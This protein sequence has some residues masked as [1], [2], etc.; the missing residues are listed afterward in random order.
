MPS[1]VSCV[2]WDTCSGLLSFF[3]TKNRILKF[4]LVGL[5]FVIVQP[6][7]VFGAPPNHAKAV[8]LDGEVTMVHIDEIIPE[9]SRFAYFLHP[10]GSKNEKDVVEMVFEG[11][12]PTF[13]RT[14]KKVR[15]RGRG[16]KGKVWISEV[17]ALDGES[18]AGNETETAGTATSG[19]RK[20]ITFVIN[21][22][23]VDYVEQGA[24]PYTQTHVQ[25]SGKAMHDPVEF[26]VNSAYE[27]ASFGQVTFSG[28]TSTDVFL[29]TIPYDS[30]ESCA[31]RTIASQAD[32][33]SPVSLQGYRH[34]L[35]VVPPK[36]ISG[37]GWLALG[38]VGSYGGTSVRKS[39][40]TRIDPIAFA[41]E[42]GHNI[43]WHHA[44]TDPDNDGT[45]NVEYGD[46]SDLM[47]YCCSKRKLN[48]VHVDQVGW[49]ERNDLQDRVVDVT[50]AGQYTLTPL[51]TDPDT[52]S[53]PQILRITPSVGRPYY[54]SYRQKTGMDA[55]MSST[56]TTG[57][58]IHRGESSDNWSYLVKVLKSDFTDANLYEFHD[59][60]N[61]LTITQIE[62][63]SSFVKVDISFGEDGECVVGNTQVALTPLD[64]TITDLSQGQSF[65]L[66]ITNNDSQECESSN[67]AVSLDS[68]TDAQGNP[69]SE[70]SG[71]LTSS[72]MSVAPQA[73]GSTGV[74][75]SF[76]DVSNG[77]YDLK[78]TVSDADV[79]EPQHDG[80]ATAS[81]E[82]SVDVCTR[83]TPTVTLTPSE[84]LVSD[85]NDLQPY[86]LTL[87]NNDSELCETSTWSVGV[88][89]DVE[90]T[91]S[92]STL[93]LVPGGKG[94]ATLA[95]Q[96]VGK[97]DGTY[98][99]TVQVSDS[100]TKHSGE[101]TA[102]L[103]LDLSGPTPPANLAAQLT[104]KGR[105]QAVQ[106]SWEQASDG[107]GGTG[108]A[109][110][111]IYR[112]QVMLG[113]TTGMNY[114]DSSFSTT[115]ENLYEV[116]AVDQVGHPSSMPASTTYMYS[117]GGK[118]SGGG[119]GK[120]K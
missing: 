102:S 6:L 99:I 68:I 1:H 91:V 45:K 11:K 111:V 88:S 9:H 29:V 32:A 48:S 63:N 110:Y 30:T 73:Q 119:K 78:V 116:F 79:E 15:V 12:P 120:K 76:G 34:K 54:L 47:G 55:G 58:N 26:S 83:E 3:R 86:T 44:A 52:S 13:I 27:E 85:V 92:T 50:N 118:K 82:V 105:N 18:S 33:A 84:Q 42:L 31:Y 100:I 114:K 21:M 81:L 25:N 20:T 108:V 107:S 41:H 60:D 98:P 70:I 53:D 17:A 5:L 115:V 103:Q 74:D 35:Y 64:S 89:S 77:T 94:S 10:K 16:A 65:T 67:Y 37:C 109:K 80:Q 7:S 112:N 69:V 71:S 101:G 40:S 62:N 49:F 61:N 19:D 57:V 22:S 106:L 38:E 59:P 46:T 72:N 51:G 23:G 28:S 96:I 56:Y 95:M 104:G 66:N 2:N 14:G 97:A 90:H 39:W 4:G 8:F 93:S 43:G 87:T 36:A 75:L 24:S 113:S 117:G